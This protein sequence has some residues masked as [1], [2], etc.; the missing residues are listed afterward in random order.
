MVYVTGKNITASLINFSSIK[1][2]RAVRSVVGAKH[3]GIADACNASIVLKNDIN[4][5]TVQ[6]MKIKIP[7]DSKTIF[8]IIIRNVSKKTTNDLYQ[9]AG[10]AYKEGTIS[11]VIWIRRY[12][13]QNWPE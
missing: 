12:Y 6:S 7:T 11:D 2:R 3:F 1:C 8:N 5:I 13:Y 10:Y 9:A 4:K